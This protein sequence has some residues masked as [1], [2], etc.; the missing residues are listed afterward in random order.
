MQKNS[1]APLNKLIDNS[2]NGYDLHVITLVDAG[3]KPDSQ[4]INGLVIFNQTASAFKNEK[5]TSCMKVVLHHVSTIDIGQ[6]NLIFEK[7]LDFIWRHTH[8]SAI[9]LNLYHIVDPET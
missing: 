4:S 9:R 7:T 1:F 5:G 8:C 3:I 2:L 6:R